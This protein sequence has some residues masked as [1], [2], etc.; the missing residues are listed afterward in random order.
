M[1]D[2]QTQQRKPEGLRGGTEGGQ[3]ARAVDV[4][5]RDEGTPGIAAP[6]GGVHNASPSQHTPTTGLAERP[7]EDARLAGGKSVG[8]VM[9]YLAGVEFPAKKDTIIRAAR[10]QGAP[11]DVLGSLMVLPATEY[12]GPDALLRDYPRLPTKD[13]IE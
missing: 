10:R 9:D 6:A 4:A 13:E 3:A 5:S 11:E 2:D 7:L 8:A 12:D 1:T